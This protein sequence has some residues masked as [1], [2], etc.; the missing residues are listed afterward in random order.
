MMSKSYPLSKELRAQLLRQLVQKAVAKHGARIG[1]ELKSINEEF[2]S[3]H[4]ERVKVMLG[5]PE[6]RCPELSG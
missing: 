1:A 6:L 4:V 5:L 2:W 3:C